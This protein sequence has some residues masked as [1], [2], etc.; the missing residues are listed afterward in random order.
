MS[1]TIYEILM[2]H[3]GICLKPYHCTSGKLTIGV[4][5]NLEDLGISKDEAFI[6]L[7]SDVTR[8]RQGLDKYLPWWDE[9]PDPIKIVLQSMAFQLGIA[10][11]LKFK[12][13]LAALQISAYSDAANHMLESAWAKQTPNRAEELA[14]M[15]AAAAFR[16]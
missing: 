7:E 8:V 2:R 12:R 13:F 14:A 4:G 11:I 15:V 9:K 1:E 3:E 6:L 16:I 5:R 10:G